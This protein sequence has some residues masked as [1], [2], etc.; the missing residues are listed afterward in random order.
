[1]CVCVCVS[2]LT[3]RLS[4]TLGARTLAASGLRCEHD[5]MDLPIVVDGT[6]RQEAV[7]AGIHHAYRL[8]AHCT[9]A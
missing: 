9:D 3:K 1:M 5:S 7:A 4:V 8:H 6:L 2:L